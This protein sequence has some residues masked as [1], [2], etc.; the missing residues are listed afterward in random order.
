MTVHS[1]SDC[2][3][4][5]QPMYVRGDLVI[6]LI[7]GGTLGA[8]QFPLMCGTDAVSCTCL[9]LFMHHCSQIR[10]VAED[11]FICCFSFHIRSRGKREREKLQGT[12]VCSVSIFISDQYA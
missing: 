12:N 6:A 11:H 4:T 9:Q 7:D 1:S 3:E 5:E 8:D 10:G 2:K